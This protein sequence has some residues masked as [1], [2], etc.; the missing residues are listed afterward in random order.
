MKLIKIFLFLFIVSLHLHSEQ[1]IHIENYFLKIYENEKSEF[2]KCIKEENQTQKKCKISKLGNDASYLLFGKKFFHENEYRPLSKFKLIYPRKYQEQ[3]IEG[4]AIAKFDISADGKVI[5]S[6]IIQ[7]KCGNPRSPFTKY[8][9]CKGFNT[10]VLRALKKFKYKPAKFE[11]KSIVVKDAL[12]R[13][14]F[15]MEDDELTIRKGKS[16][17]YNNVL[18][19][20]TKKNFDEAIELAESNLEFDYIFMTQIANAKYQQGKYLDAIDWSNKFNGMVLNDQRDIP[21]DIMVRGFMR[22]I[23]S[24]F[25]VGEYEELINYEPEFN[26]YIKERKKYSELLAMTNFYFGVSYINLGQVQKGAYYLGLAAKNS[27]SKAESD[28]VDSVI[29]KI[30]SYL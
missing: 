7:A 26:N 30:S 16:R 8:R 25:N 29:D 18:K 21:E 28:Y 23:S 22:L 2:E 11:E 20:I 9:N 12:H 5:N 19:A 24:L 4:F 6:K 13:F 27:N 3:G 10:E 15:I 17:Q 1:N 14:N